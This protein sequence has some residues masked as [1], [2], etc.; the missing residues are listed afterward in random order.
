[1]FTIAPVLDWP[2]NIFINIHITR[3]RSE[4]MEPADG[5]K[6]KCLINK[7]TGLLHR[8]KWVSCDWNDR[9]RMQ[10]IVNSLLIRSARSF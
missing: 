4:T 9:N 1:M 3:V 10:G 5:T 2:F 6:L 8:K 7:M